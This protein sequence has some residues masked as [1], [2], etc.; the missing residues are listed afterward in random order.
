MKLILK[1]SVLGGLALLLLVA[2]G[3]IKGLTRERKGRLLDVKNNIAASYAREQILVGPVVTL[4]YREHWTHRKFS[5]EENRWIEEEVSETRSTPVFPLELRFESTL[6]V[7][8]RYRGIFKAN[9]FLSSGTLQGSIELP[10]AASLKTKSDSR[11]EWV[12]ATA[13]VHVRDPRGISTPPGVQW[14]DSPRPVRTGSRLE[15]LPEGF[16]APL[17]RE[18][19]DFALTANFKIDLHIHGM[20]EFQMVPI[21]ADNHLRL[22]SSW[23]HP[24]F[25]GDFLATTRTV[26][27]DGF[28][29]EWNV[30]GL[31]SS[32]RQQFTSGEA[33]DL[34]TMGV[35]LI[36]PVTPYPMTDRALKYSFLFIFLTFAAFLLFELLRGLQIHP[37]QYGFVGLAQA[38]FFLLLLGLSE[39]IRF[40]AAYLIATLACCS[41]ITLYLAGVLGTRRQ[42]YAFGGFLTLLYATL[43]GLLQSE[44]HALVAGSV[45]LFGLLS[46]VMLFTRNINWYDPGNRTASFT[47]VPTESEPAP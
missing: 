14:M 7:E 41:I 5:R 47:I 24:S 44:D 2:L 30:N 36:D 17:T 27:E 4:N 29:A 26:R 25:I 10:E 35:D 8:E 11:I 40:G 38:L 37:V 19:A 23:P 20:Q 16:H 32:A 13:G 42:S 43:Y 28:T 9:V 12:S 15:Q 1:L 22:Q 46:A 6:R 18:D 31:A 34:Q 45:L 3:S 33:R 39:H 21:A